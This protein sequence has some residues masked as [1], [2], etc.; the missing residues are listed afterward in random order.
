MKLM[1]NADVFLDAYIYE[2]GLFVSLPI[3]CFM[4]LDDE[5]YHDKK[6]YEE[7]KANHEIVQGSTLTYW[8]S[9]NVLELWP[10]ETSRERAKNFASWYHIN[11]HKMKRKN[12]LF[13]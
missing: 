7:L 13:D 4:H 6:K 12:L 3:N 5:N 11:K 8:V 9:G 1:T 2:G 10:G